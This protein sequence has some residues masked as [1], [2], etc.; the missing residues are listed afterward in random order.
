MHV[1][2]VFYTVQRMAQLS[3]LSLLLALICY[4]YGR[5][6]IANGQTGR[7]WILAAVPIATPL[8]KWAVEVTR[9]ADLPR[10]VRRA[11]KV[12]TTAPTGPV[13]ISLPGESIDLAALHALHQA[14]G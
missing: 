10:I 2:T 9:L 13:F 14:L 6:R 1:S 5:L 11:A 8:V 7:G 4:L 12:A 3:T